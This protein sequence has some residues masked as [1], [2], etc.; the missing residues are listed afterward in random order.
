MNSLES[1]KR[2]LIEITEINNWVKCPIRD[3][4]WLA[5]RLLETGEACPC[6]PK[7]RPFCPC[8]QAVKEIEENGH[9]LCHEFLHP[10]YDYKK[11]KFKN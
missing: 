2:R 11:G 3:F 6:Q 9:C 5:K 1:I 10:N 7:K 8:D 4:D